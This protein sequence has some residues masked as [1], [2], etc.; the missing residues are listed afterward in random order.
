MRGNKLKP[1]FDNKNQYI[2]GDGAPDLHLHGILAVANE[3]LY[4]QMVFDV[5]E[6]EF[7]ASVSQ[8]KRSESQ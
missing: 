3:K 8:S 6:E 5:V 1:L 2:S 7:T 4:V